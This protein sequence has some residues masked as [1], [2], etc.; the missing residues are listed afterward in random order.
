MIWVL[1]ADCGHFWNELRCGQ[2]LRTSNGFARTTI[3]PWIND[4]S[5][6][7]NIC[8]NRPICNAT[9][10]LRLIYISLF[11]LCRHKRRS[12]IFA[13]MYLEI[14][15]VF[16]QYLAIQ[17]ADCCHQ[18]EFWSAGVQR[19]ALRSVWLSV[20]VLRLQEFVF[21]PPILICSICWPTSRPTLSWDPGNSLMKRYVFP[22][23]N[24]LHDIICSNAWN[25]YIL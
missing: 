9:S 13:D 20:W 23:F 24:R 2:G 12:W 10:S 19:A 8:L 6:S 4:G 7:V 14:C 16:G 3:I 1:P 22:Y 5:R 21:H 25:T 11:C 15:N 17:P 18:N